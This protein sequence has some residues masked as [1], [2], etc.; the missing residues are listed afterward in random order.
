MKMIA[1]HVLLLAALSSPWACSSGS[2]PVDIG[3]SRTGEKLGDYAAVWEG[4]VEAYNFRDGS[5]KIKLT[6]DAAGN[7]TLEI[8]DSAPLPPLD[9]DPNVGYPSG[10]LPLGNLEGLVPGFSYPIT[11]A[12]VEL[13]RVRLS[14]NPLE[15][16]SDWCSLQ[17][18]YQSAKISAPD[19]GILYRCIPD[20]SGFGDGT[21]CSYNGEAIDCVKLDACIS[22]YCSCDV[23][24]CSGSSGNP[25]SYTQFDAALDVGGNSLVGTLKI[26]AEDARSSMTVRL[27]R[28]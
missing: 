5:D 12:T 23:R 27:K 24:G 2:A 20:G 17:T 14:V 19:G 13:A 7:G 3:D 4:Y 9:P 26:G 1:R 15:I 21:G 28:H 11:P 8:G 22:G 25:K 16:E 18:S 6:L 10:T